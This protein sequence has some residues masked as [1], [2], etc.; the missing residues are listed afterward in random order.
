MLGENERLRSLCE[1][2][3]VEQDSERLLELVREIN[4]LLEAREKRS[5]GGRDGDETVRSARSA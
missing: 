5:A 3:A 2:A 1:Q 4:K